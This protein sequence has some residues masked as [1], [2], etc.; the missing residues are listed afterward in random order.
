MKE[1]MK[2]RETEEERKCLRETEREGERAGSH[3]LIYWIIDLWTEES[4]Y[5]QSV[6]VCVC[7]SLAHQHNSATPL[8]SSSAPL[9]VPSGSLVL[10]KLLM[11]LRPDLRSAGS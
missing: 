5:S 9:L 3:L 1:L 8:C 2:K 10:L 7:V 11:F 6:S 4:R